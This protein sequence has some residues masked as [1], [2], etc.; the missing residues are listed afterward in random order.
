MFIFMQA[1]RLQP[2]IYKES[3]RSLNYLKLLNTVVKRQA[4]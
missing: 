4:L 1:V 2:D 3:E